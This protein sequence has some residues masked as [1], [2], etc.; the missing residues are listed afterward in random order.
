M[1][2]CSQQQSFHPRLLESSVYGLEVQAVG[3]EVSTARCQ[4]DPILE[5]FRVWGSGLR[6]KELGVR[7]GE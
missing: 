5:G 2:M 4:G 6:K 3:V 7:P 1:S